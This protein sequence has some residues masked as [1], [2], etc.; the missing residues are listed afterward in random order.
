M[1]AS[2]IIALSSTSA[3]GETPS[4]GRADAPPRSQLFVDGD[5]LQRGLLGSYCWSGA[6]SQ[7]CGMSEETEYPRQA[8]AE[9][10]RLEVHLRKFD[11]PSELR[12]YLVGGEGEPSTYREI[13]AIV[14]PRGDAEGWVASL[15]LGTRTFGPLKLLVKARWPHLQSCPPCADD[16]AEWRFNVAVPKP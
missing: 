7:A 1:A 11:P 3:V 16:F 6:G 12:A 8:R 9:S 2:A 13:P 15:R 14:T 10:R 5:F 4:R